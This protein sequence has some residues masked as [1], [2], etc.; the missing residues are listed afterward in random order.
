M[1]AF[2]RVLGGQ[3]SLRGI[4]APASAA[5]SITE[6]AAAPGIY[7]GAAPASAA[8]S[9]A[10]V[11]ASVV[12]SALERLDAVNPPPMCAH[13]DPGVKQRKRDARLPRWEALRKPTIE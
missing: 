10:V 8:A 9:P 11:K 6:V 2:P 4:A 1:R 5:V 13:H 7:A 3:A 12:K